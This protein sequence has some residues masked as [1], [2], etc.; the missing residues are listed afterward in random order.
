MGD[1]FD[2][3]RDPNKKLKTRNE[4]LGMKYAKRRAMLK[5]GKSPLVQAGRA[6]NKAPTWGKVGIA[7]SVL[8]PKALILGIAYAGA[9]SVNKKDKKQ[10]KKYMAG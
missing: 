4:N 1:G 3:Y 2:K 6:W 7:S 8:I 5:K 9:K 10:P